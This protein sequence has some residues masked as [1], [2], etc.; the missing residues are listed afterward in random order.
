MKKKLF[1]VLVVLSVLVCF[2]AV[3]TAVEW[4]E[5]PEY[6]V[7]GVIGASCEN[8]QA[9]ETFAMAPSSWYNGG[10]YKTWVDYIASM[11]RKDY[12]WLNYAAAGE[13][14]VNGITHLNDMLTQ[15]VVPGPDGMPV[16]TVKILVI[17]FWGNDVAWLPGYHQAVMDALLQNV[18]DQ[19]AMAK[20]A[21]VEKIIITGWPKYNDL[22]LD[23]IVSIFPELTTH[24]DEEGY[25][26]MK[27]QYYNAFSQPN[28]DY[29]FVEPW[30][31]YQVFDG[32]HPGEATSKR[33][34]LIMRNAV[35]HYD[36]YVN[37]KSLF[38][39]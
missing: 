27:E 20:S 22:D 26:Q 14:S 4:V 35:K 38:C 13:V 12:H 18:N 23:Y 5:S 24:I 17:G 3:G 10:H 7:A 36:K 32:I 33:A 25:N 30:C 8:A 21:G 6:I 2:A 34:A 39:R 37:Q 29:I 1:T 11:Q 19:I 9:P 16:T 28:P 15:A 31:R